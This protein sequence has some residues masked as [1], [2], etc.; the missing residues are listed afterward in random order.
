[1]DDSKIVLLLDALKRERDAIFSGEFDVMR[2]VSQEKNELLEVIDFS[3]HPE[4]VNFNVTDH[5]Q[6]NQKVLAAVIQGVKSAMRQLEKSSGGKGITSIYTAWGAK[7]VVNEVNSNN[8]R[9]F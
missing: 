9:K 1:M 3:T 2:Q 8:S 6:R 7:S 5:L 4:G